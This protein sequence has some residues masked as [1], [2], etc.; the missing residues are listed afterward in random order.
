MNYI[1]VNNIN[2]KE[3]IFSNKL[4]E[5]KLLWKGHKLA[6]SNDQHILKTLLKIFEV[7]NQQ[8]EFSLDYK[9]WN[10]KFLMKEVSYRDNC[11]NDIST[12]GLDKTYKDILE[13]MTNKFGYFNKLFIYE[14]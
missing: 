3:I 10:Q 9:I 13:I 7:R 5:Y 14:K 12:Y 1:V 4:L 8:K 2:D 6:I 11:W